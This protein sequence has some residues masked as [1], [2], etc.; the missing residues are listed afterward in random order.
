MKEVPYNKSDIRNIGIVAHIDAGKTTTTERILYYSGKTYKIGEV[1]DGNAEMDWMEQEKE[2]GITITSAATTCYWKKHRVNIIDTPGH[3]DFTAEVER[4]LRVLDGVIGVFCGVA[5]VEPQSETVW[6]QADRYDIPRLAFVNKMDRVGA[7]FDRVIQSMKKRLSG[8]IV[9]V[10]WPI[11]AGKDLEGIIDLIEMK[12]YYWHKTDYGAKYDTRE[13]PEQYLEMA[14]LQREM[15]LETVV[16]FDD[17]VMDKYLSG[18]SLS[19]QD[20]KTV[21]RKAVIHHKVVPVFAGSSL[22]NIGVQPLLDAVID[23]LPSPEDVKIFPIHSVHNK[24]IVEKKAKDGRENFIGLAFKVMVDPHR[25]KMIFIKVYSGQLKVGEQIYNV[26]KDKKERVGKLLLMH[27]NKQEE[28]DTASWGDI[29]VIVGAKF[30]H[31]GDTLTY[32]KSETLLEPMSFPLPVISVSIEPKSAAEQDK[33]HEVL[34]LL[35]EEDPTFTSTYNQETGQIIMS[36]MGELHLDILTTRILKDFKVKANVGKPQVSY[37]ET[38]TKSVVSRM[39]Y[40]K[41]IQGHGQFGD[42]EIK[43]TPLERKSG[44]VFKNSV[45]DSIIPHNFIKSI[46][47]SAR[48][49]LKSGYKAGYEVIDLEIELV[50]GSFNETDST[51]VAYQIA[52]GMAIEECLKKGEP[53]LLEPVMKVEIITPEDFLGDV[54]SDLNLR[55]SQVK[56]IDVFTIETQRMIHAEIP[57]SEMFGYATTLRSLSQGRATY[58]MEFSH[59]DKVPVSLEKKILGI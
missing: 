45:P 17:V 57:L 43:L 2:R 54:I 38:I 47:D 50:S 25:G 51:D 11:G 13:I 39:Q 24:E 49:S 19:I 10:Q 3:V 20:I 32:K 42:V 48:S 12:A 31:T 55:R 36:G 58:S 1:H 33:L 29:V 27:A 40:N 8:I 7:N 5:G 59:Y 53:I 22:K 46:E 41:E 30:T 28:I 9:P 26:N 15:M 56:G 23:Y 4:A 34:N 44:V 21:L 52:T 6:N 18:E 35:A 14:E 16:E 37:R